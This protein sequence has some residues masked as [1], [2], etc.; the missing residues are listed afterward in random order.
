MMMMMRSSKF[1]EMIFVGCFVRGCDFCFIHSFI[2]ISLNY[3]PV[4]S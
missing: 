3:G 2:H 1:E 4:V